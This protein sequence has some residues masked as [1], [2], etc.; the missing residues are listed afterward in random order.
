[1]SR[2]WG[3]EFNSDNPPFLWIAARDKK[4]DSFDLV[5]NSSPTYKVSYQ[6]EPEPE[7][8]PTRQPTTASII[9]AVRHLDRINADDYDTWLKVGAALWN[10]FPEVGL[11]LWD[12]WSKTS[13]K[14]SE[15]A[16]EAK[17]STFHPHDNPATLGTIRYLG[18]E[19]RYNVLDVSEFRKA[20]FSREFLIENLLVKNMPVVFGG[21]MKT[22]KTTTMMEVGVS[23]ATGTKVFDKF[24]AKKSVVGFMTGESGSWKLQDTLIAQEQAKGVQCEKGSYW[25]TEDLPRFMRDGDIADLEKLCLDRGTEVLMID[26]LYLC[27]GGAD[28]TA[29]YSMAEPLRAIGD[30][31]RVNNI[32]LMLAHHSTKGSIKP[33]EVMELHHLT[34][35]GIGEWLRQ[36]VLVS[37]RL[38]YVDGAW[39]ADLWMR[40]VSG[41]VSATYA[42]SIDENP[43]KVEVTPRSEIVSNEKELKE[44]RQRDEL[45]EHV[46]AALAGGPLTITQLRKCTGCRPARGQILEE[47]VGLGV[48]EHTT[49]KTSDSQGRSRTNKG[50]QLTGN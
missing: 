47:L 37:H 49:L 10:E 22:Y 33:G 24:Q 39:H 31:C 23:L 9:E 15:G 20:D 34:G 26:P 40:I 43:W 14:Y 17:W 32:T 12:D 27:L 3:I 29:I 21:G 19:Q 28:G 7:P 42:V 4:A 48:I 25:L 16:C 44:V 18:K 50:Y 38:P 6:P 45:G 2:E 36:A 1:M 13:P 5:S 35:A 30:M 41:F 8:E 11:Q 46:K